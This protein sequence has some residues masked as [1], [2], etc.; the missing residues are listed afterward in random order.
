M[1]LNLIVLTASRANFAELLR[2]VRLPL[3]ERSYLVTTVGVE[4]LVRSS[5]HCRDLLDEAKDYLLLPE[6]RSSLEGENKVL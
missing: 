2:N 4:P 3:L 1:Y 5:E 6:R